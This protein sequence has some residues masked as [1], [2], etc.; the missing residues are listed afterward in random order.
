MGAVLTRVVTI[1]AIAL[2]GGQ[3][4]STVRSRLSEGND[5][6]LPAVSLQERVDLNTL[7]RPGADA[8]LWVDATG[9]PTE[10]A[11][12]ALA[13]LGHVADDGLDPADFRAG[14]LDGLAS[15]LRAHPS[16][17]GVAEF[18]VTLSLGMLRYFR[19]LHLGR[20]DPRLLGF[21]IPAPTEHHDFP[22]MLRS[23]LAGGTLAE[24]VAGLSPPFEQYRALR[25]MLARYRSLAEDATLPGL[26][27][28]SIVLRPGGRYTNLG[29]LSRRLIAFGDLADRP[30]PP[31]GSTTYD[32]VLVDAVKRFQARHGLS[33]DGVIGPETHAALACP[34]TWRVR[35]IELALERLRWLPDLAR[36]RLVAVDIPMFRV[37]AF[38]VIP[39]AG[40]AT[41]DMSVIVGHAFD[42]ETPT[43]V[44]DMRY[45]IFR[46]YWYVPTSILR[47][48]VLPG[49][50]RSPDYLRSH[51][52]EIF[53][54]PV[55]D[56][57]PVPTTPENLA[58]LRK[59]VL[60]LRQRPGPRNPL[61]LVKFIFPND[62]HVYLHGTPEPELFRQTRRD[63]SH[64][65]VRV[66][67]PVAMAEWALSDQPEWTR[68]AILAAMAAAEPRRVD[69]TRPITVVFFYNTAVV[70]PDDGLIRFAADIYRQ[71]AKLDR[72]LARRSPTP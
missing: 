57:Q 6:L 30:A 5:F 40:P 46:P 35:Q 52:M 18:E 65:C 7:Y 71:D 64:G 31:E 49:I 9:Q 72:A 61:G 22:A 42:T 36:D 45:V 43:L 39:N 10:R 51:D 4:A 11:R 70:T 14:E 12:D 19:Q 23:A 1:G 20:V 58:L 8:P 56:A 41:L 17:P 34:L 25:R 13:L 3:I 55:D 68:E 62:S 26:P 47:A 15:A 2:A 29:A 33:S 37:W 21:R 48:E 66:E 28:R 60:N 50:K 24:A 27:P 67:D 53:A 32:D 16:A 54:G 59:G 44:E 38:D 69:L 63:F